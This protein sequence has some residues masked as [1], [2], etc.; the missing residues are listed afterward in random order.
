M[1]TSAMPPSA[2]RLV[3]QIKQLLQHGNFHIGA[4]E[5]GNQHPVGGMIR[6]GGNNLQS[7]HS[8]VNVYALPVLGHL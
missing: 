3:I 4:V 5:P 8:I 6:G 2:D 7:L 1:N